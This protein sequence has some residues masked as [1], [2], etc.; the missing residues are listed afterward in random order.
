MERLHAIMPATARDQFLAVCEEL[1]L[2]EG[3]RKVFGSSRQWAKQFSLNPGVYAVF[4][5]GKLAYVGESG[6]LRGRM[7]DLFD[8][9]NH[10][11]RR[12]LG[13]QRCSEIAGFEPATSKRT[14]PSHIEEWLGAYMSRSLAIAVVETPFGRREIEEHMIAKHGPLPYN[15]KSRRG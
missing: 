6:S 15:K 2:L 8:T 1:L 5:L 10:T 9:R 13:T 4:E 11:L 3:R 7:G 14:F 12:S